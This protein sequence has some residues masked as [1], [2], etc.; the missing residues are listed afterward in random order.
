MRA[1]L[2]YRAMLAAVPAVPAPVASNEQPLLAAL[3]KIISEVPAID[4]GGGFFIEHRDQDGEYI[5]SE[6]IDPVTIIQHMQGIAHF[7]IEAYEAVADGQPCD[8]CA[9]TGKCGPDENPNEMDCEVCDGSSVAPAAPID[10]DEVLEEAA[11]ACDALVESTL[12][13]KDN[14]FAVAFK[15]QGFQKA[16][17]SIRAMKGSPA[18]LAVPLPA[19]QSEQVVQAVINVLES[20][21]LICGRTARQIELLR[22]DLA[23]ELGLAVA[24]SHQPA[25]PATPPAAPEVPTVNAEDIRKTA[26]ALIGELTGNQAESGDE[27]EAFLNGSARGI[28][29]LHA[30][31]LTLMKLRTLSAAPTQTGGAK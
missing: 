4:E 9:G 23:Q 31:L 30:E 17:T 15:R 20:H 26:M 19:D 24:P 10:R 22:I 8:E 6:Q 11:R 21:S 27:E 5:G 28:G 12:P 14:E 29:S 3:R 1:A 2:V 16:A 13:G 7:A 25:A 18:P